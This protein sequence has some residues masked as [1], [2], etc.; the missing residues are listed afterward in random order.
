ML[1]MSLHE[2]FTWIHLKK[3]LLDNFLSKGCHKGKGVALLTADGSLEQPT[4]TV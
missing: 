2:K 3:S 1:F 4:L